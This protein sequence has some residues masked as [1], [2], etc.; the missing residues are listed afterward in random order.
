MLVELDVKNG[1]AKGPMLYEVAKAFAGE[2]YEPKYA[3]KTF[4][5]CATSTSDREIIDLTYQEYLWAYAQSK[6]AGHLWLDLKEDNL[7]KIKAA[8]AQIKDR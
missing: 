7:P 5:Y 1:Y 8:F 6:Q 3:G 4:L 2:L